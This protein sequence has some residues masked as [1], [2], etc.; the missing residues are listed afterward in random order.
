MTTATGSTAGAGSTAT[1]TRR[2]EPARR[3]RA[4]LELVTPLGWTLLAL[5]VATFVAGRWLGWTE[6]VIVA[7]VFGACLVIAVG[8][9]FGKLVLDVDI[10]VQP[11]RV[12]AGRR[13]VAQVTV[14]NT[15]GRRAAGFVMELG[16]GLGAA[17]FSVPALHSGDEHDE[18]FVLPTLRRAVIPVG[19]ATSVRSDPLGVLRRALTWTGTVPL[20]VHPPTVPLGGGGIGLLRDLEGLVTNALSAA[21]VAFHTLREYQTGDDRRFIHALASAKA[22]TM[23]VRQF[24]D[25]R[26]IHHA[27]VIDGDASSYAND[28]EYDLAISMAASLAVRTL[29]E[30]QEV[31]MMAAG[32]RVPTASPTGMLDGLAAAELA[33]REANLVAQI[34]PLMR[35]ASAVSLA[36]LVTGSR[37]KLAEVRSAVVQVPDDVGVLV[38][39]A[40]SG[41]NPEFRPIGKAMVLTAGALDD[42]P[43]LVRAVARS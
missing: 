9:T 5:S 36:V 43:R 16:V 20:Y 22:G 2:R 34:D 27:V 7:G 42:F 38:L 29:I 15:A 14:R 8:F 35:A 31:S 3:V 25:T 26:R 41:H 32:H 17:E 37:P 1:R 28:D 40:A 21:D 12:V 11:Q 10:E 33:G 18:V 6:L 23:M 4:A 39:R 30:D 24:I 13:A 19:P